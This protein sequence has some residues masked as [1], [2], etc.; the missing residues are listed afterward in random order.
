MLANMCIRSML[1]FATVFCVVVLKYC[2]TPSRAS[3]AH[4]TTFVFTVC[5]GTDHV[6]H[7][8]PSRGHCQSL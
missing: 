6:D 8:S 4:I 7:I 3:A 5:K 1:V 2:S